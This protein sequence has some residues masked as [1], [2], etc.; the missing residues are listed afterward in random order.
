MGKEGGTREKM[1]RW[2]PN[3]KRY[4]YH[5]SGR[6]KTSMEEENSPKRNYGLKDDEQE[7][8][9]THNRKLNR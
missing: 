6:V 2:I 8:W 4:K 3:R 5:K 7:R 9:S 1:R